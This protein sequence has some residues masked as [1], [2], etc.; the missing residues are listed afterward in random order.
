MKAF[1]KIAAGAIA[2]LML[3]VPLAANAQELGG[4]GMRAGCGW[5]HRDIAWD[6]HKLRS[7]WRDIHRDRW[8][9]Q[10]DLANGNWAAA[11]AERNDLRR[12]YMNVRR[13][14]WDLQRDYRPTPGPG[15]GWGYAPMGYVSGPQI[16]YMAPAVRPLP[17]NVPPANPY[18]AGYGSPLYPSGPASY[19]GPNGQG[20]G[21]LLNG[22]V[23]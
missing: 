17:V 14:R 9:L 1:R 12:D 7:Q 13:Q 20:L 18:S 16:N 8:E 5:R 2:L 3:A 15:P 6:R 23:P 22:L 4:P 10:R 19:A 11:Q 21:A